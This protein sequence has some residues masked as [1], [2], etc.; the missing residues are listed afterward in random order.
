[1]DLTWDKVK[2]KSYPHKCSKWESASNFKFESH[3]MGFTR[4]HANKCE[5]C[6]EGLSAN[7]E[8]DAM[9]LIK[10]LTGAP[11]FNHYICTYIMVV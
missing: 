1:M 10:F 8:A 6:S 11:N 4:I 2:P 9:I 7:Y 3:F 5:L